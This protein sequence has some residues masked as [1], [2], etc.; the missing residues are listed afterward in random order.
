MLTKSVGNEL[1]IPRVARIIPNIKTAA[2]SCLPTGFMKENLT[3]RRE[4]M[5]TPT[6]V[7]DTANDA[8]ANPL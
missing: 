3:Y 2:I 7:T 8:N 1:I 4:T 5:R 6:D